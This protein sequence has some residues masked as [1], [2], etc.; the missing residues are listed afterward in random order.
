MHKTK[1]RYSRK[2]KNLGLDPRK[3]IDINTDKFAN[4]KNQHNQLKVIIYTLYLSDDQKLQTDTHTRARAHKL[5]QTNTHKHSQHAHT[6]VNQCVCTNK[7]IYARTHKDIHAQQVNN[8]YNFS[9]HFSDVL[10]AHI[11]RQNTLN[12]TS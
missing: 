11:S 10:D 12:P 3:V 9:G 5:E 8:N 1:I 6:H 4:D 7:Q 2:L